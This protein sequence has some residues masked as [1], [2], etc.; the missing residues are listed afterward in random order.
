MFTITCDCAFR[1]IRWTFGLP[2]GGEDGE[3][4][5]R[6]LVCRRI[7]CRRLRY[8]QAKRQR[9]GGCAL[10]MLAL[11]V[12]H[13]HAQSEGT[14]KPELVL[15]TAHTN[16]ITALAFSP[17]GRWLV[18]AENGYEVKLWDTASGLQVRNISVDSPAFV[19]TFCADGTWLATAYPLE[20]VVNLWKVRTGEK[21]GTLEGHRDAIWSMAV[22]P[23]AGWM[24][25]GSADKTVGLWD[26]ESGKSM[27]FLGGFTD[28]IRA[29][30]KACWCAVKRRWSTAG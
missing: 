18:T 20:H 25:T 10:L 4:R 21:I 2:N 5:M 29:L 12:A 15:Q 24:A 8:A 7:A 22:S 23:D 27:K 6:R 16:G 26:L 14:A 9:M 13:V 3:L 11:G 19:M 28:M 17:D 1:G 30:A